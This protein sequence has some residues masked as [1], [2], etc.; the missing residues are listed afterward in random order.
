MA[1]PTVRCQIRTGVVERRAGDAD[2]GQVTGLLR[3][4]VG[5]VKSTAREPV[6][7]HVT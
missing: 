5:G 2:P 6:C 7:S 4:K 1:E 3:L